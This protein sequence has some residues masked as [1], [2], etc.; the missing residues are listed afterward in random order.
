MVPRTDD[1]DD[2]ANCLCFALRRASRTMTQ[3]YGRGTTGDVR[4]TQSPILTALSMK[5]RWEMAELSDALGLDRTTL[6]RNLMPLRRDG[7]VSVTA[8]AGRRPATVDITRKG[9]AARSHLLPQWRKAQKRVIGV[10]G[11][12]RWREIMRDLKRVDAALRAEA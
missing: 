3:F 12:E 11:E 1:L 10:L 6:V 7:L 5:P 8:G 4:A 9:L 2:M